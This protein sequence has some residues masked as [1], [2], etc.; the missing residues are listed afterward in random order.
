MARQKFY[1]ATVIDPRYGERWFCTEAE[2]IANGW[3]KNAQ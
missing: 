2:A 3:R 1:H